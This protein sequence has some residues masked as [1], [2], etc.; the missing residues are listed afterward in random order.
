MSEGGAVADADAEVV[1]LER[2]QRIGLAAL[3]S[4]GPSRSREQLARVEHH[5]RAGRMRE[6]PQEQARGIGEI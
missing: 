1:V 3:T 6:G 4:A 2:P 5:S